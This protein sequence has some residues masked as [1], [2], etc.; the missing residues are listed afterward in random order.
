ME[1]ARFSH[2]YIVTGPPDKTEDA[3]RR[4]AAGLLCA[5]P[6]PDGAAC[7]D[8]VHCR[9]LRRGTHPDLIVLARQ[10][11]DKGKP[12]REIY[13]DQIRELASSAPVLPNEAARKVYLIREAG[14]MNPAAQ[15]ALLK[16]LEEPPPFDAFVLETDSAAA[17]LETVRSRC[18]LRSAG[19]GEDAPPAE[20]RELAERWIDLA[21]AGARVSLISFANENAEKSTAELSDFARAARGLL[22]DMLCARLPA[23][24]LARPE[25]LRLV[26][27]TD[28]CAEYLR[29][30]VS[31][32]HVLGMLSAET[33]I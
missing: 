5:H 25:L 22:T 11:D 4:L 33:V 14:T 7:G 29:F 13:V 32:K 30:N 21:A 8:C 24:G 18:V 16:L 6:G 1:Q 12:K 17:L 2:A 20:A 28:R 19:E 27:L 31:V 10:T 15:N 26:E 9:K 23:R 3:A